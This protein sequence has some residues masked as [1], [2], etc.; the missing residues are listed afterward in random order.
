[1]EFNVG[2][3][4]NVFRD[5]DNVSNVN[6]IREIMRWVFLPFA[7]RDYR[8][9]VHIT[10]VDAKDCSSSRALSYERVLMRQSSY[11]YK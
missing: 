9:L 7:A 11:N 6:L 1:V 5:A 10:R 8:P 4:Q 3:S 2:L